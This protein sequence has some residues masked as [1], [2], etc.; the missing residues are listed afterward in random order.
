MC[1]KT[2]MVIAP[3]RL[4]ES[5][6]TR[7]KCYDIDP[8]LFVL[9]SSSLSQHPSGVV[10]YHQ[11]Y[12]GRTTPVSGYE[13]YPMGKAVTDIRSKIILDQQPLPNAPPEVLNA[14]QHMVR[15]FKSDFLNGMEG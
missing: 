14:L 8:V 2:W 10:A 1:G 4:D 11:G 7:E 9:D 5:K 13:T 12:D 6:A 3:Y 15:K